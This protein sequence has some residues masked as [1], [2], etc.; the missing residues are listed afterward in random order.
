M[1]L[2]IDVGN[3]RIKWAFWDGH[4]LESPQSAN[5]RGVNFDR[6]LH[7][8]WRNIEQPQSILITNV[9]GK[10]IDAALQSWCNTIWELNPIT[11]KTGKEA[12]GVLN[13]YSEPQTLGVDRWLGLV[14]AY[15]NLGH[16]QAVCVIDCG[17]CLTVDV[18]NKSGI[19][20]GGLLLPGVQSMRQALANFTDAC[21]ISGSMTSE[22]PSL[23]AKNTSE[24][25]IGGTLFAAVSHV[26]R[27]IQEIKEELRADITCIL[28]GGEA[29]SIKE[30][31]QFE[32][33]Y[34]PHLVLEGMTYY[35]Q[36]AAEKQG[37]AHS[38]FH[39]RVTQAERF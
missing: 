19:H 14:A 35:A 39:E 26:D 7:H 20:M 8:L 21:H 34:Q 22:S 28:T 24:G 23:L 30:L 2:L 13:G 38:P 4:K 9:A 1:Q 3:S 25:I 12:F 18:V 11:L 6:L 5:H 27:L 32:H 17:T 29:A 10:E 15:Q 36:S 31:V 33:Q 37:A 16:S